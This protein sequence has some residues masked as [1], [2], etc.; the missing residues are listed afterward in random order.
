[1]FNGVAGEVERLP[2]IKVGDGA[3]GHTPFQSLICPTQR[4]SRKPDPLGSV[5]SHSFMWRHTD[6][7]KNHSYSCSRRVSVIKTQVPLPG[8]G[9]VS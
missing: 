5:V 3:H 7:Q 4:L 2:P 8:Y 9:V 1:M 6:A